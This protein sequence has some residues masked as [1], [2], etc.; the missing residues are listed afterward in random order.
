MWSAFFALNGLWMGGIRQTMS[1]VAGRN[2]AAVAALER[3]AFGRT[4]DIVLES[5]E[6]LER[7]LG[8]PRNPVLI[9]LLARADILI[10][11]RDLLVRAVAQAG[12]LLAMPPPPLVYPNAVALVQEIRDGVARLPAERE[13]MRSLVRGALLERIINL[14]YIRTGCADQA[15]TRSSTCCLAGQRTERRPG[16]KSTF[17]TL[18][19]SCA[20]VSKS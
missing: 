11:E 15:T 16:K 4:I 13:P 8:H 19:R 18:A 20:R 7:E 2:P 3:T 12:S 5:P 6:S 9:R 14:A 10:D 17:V 1:T